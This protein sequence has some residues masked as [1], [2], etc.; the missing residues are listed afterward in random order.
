MSNGTLLL[1][2]TATP[3]ARGMTALDDAQRAASETAVA[4]SPRAILVFADLR[5]D[6]RQSGQDR[7][8]AWATLALAAAGDEPSVRHM[9][10]AVMLAPRHAGRFD[11]VASALGARIHSSLERDR[12]RDVEVTFLD[13]SECSSVATLT[14][15]LLNRCDDAT[16]PHGVV[17]L[18]WDDIRDHSIAFAARN[19]YL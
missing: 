17:V 11:R 15:R 12:A 3:L 14:E 5:E 8:R 7:L 9:V 19:E 1:G 18:D 4:T 6:G 2:D 16:G 10:F 13:V